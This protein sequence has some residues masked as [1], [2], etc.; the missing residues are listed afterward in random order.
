MKNMCED[1]PIDGGAAVQADISQTFDRVVVINLARRPE[2]LARFWSVLGDWPFARPQRFEAVDGMA[3]GIPDGWDKGAG[4]WGCMLSHRAVLDSAIQD[5]IGSLLVLEDDAYP[6]TG[7]A[8][9]AREFLE[10]VPTDWDCL[11][12]G[13]QHLQPPL[14]INGGVV[15]CVAANRTHGYAVRGRMMTVLSQF[16]S[17]TKNDHCDLVLSSLMRHFKAY[18]P[19]PLLIGQDAG[20][21]D[22]T[23]RGER[24]RFLSAQSKEA[25]A[26]S[27]SRHG[28]EKLVVR[29]RPT[30]S[31]AAQACMA[32]DRQLIASQ[33]S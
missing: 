11:M 10:Q 15:R 23:G 1:K 21:S 25:I 3:V 8:R 33:D 13:A 12:L 2:R 28:I 5:G 29:V 30:I 17:Q 20:Q 31:P 7:F 14:P 19:N 4:A 27:D 26:A 22:V 9:L 16:W 18:A 6:V 32:L 24:L